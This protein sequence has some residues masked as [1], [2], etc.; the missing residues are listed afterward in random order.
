MVKLFEYNTCVALAL[1]VGDPLRISV[2]L[3]GSEVG[4][5]PLTCVVVKCI[6]TID[7]STYCGTDYTV[8]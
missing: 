3:L 6:N 7:G 4:E 5:E 2:P 1:G 8:I